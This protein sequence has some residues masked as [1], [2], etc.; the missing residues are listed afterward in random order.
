MLQ[1]GSL[2]RVVDRKS[3]FWNGEG[4]I[5]LINHDSKSCIVRF[6]HEMRHKR[7]FNPEG[8]SFKHRQLKEIDAFSAR[9]MCE[10]VAS[11]R[12][13]SSYGAH[14]DF[15][16]GE[17]RICM[18]EGCDESVPDGL[19]TYYNDWGTVVRCRMCQAHH[20]KWNFH[21]TEAVTLKDRMKLEHKPEPAPA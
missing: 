1:L 6:G 9:V 14:V 13:M 15:I 4:E 17:D 12:C 10:R 21:N 2:V 20:D 16:E 18:V 19:Y 8:N 11:F 7:D 5:V 3:V